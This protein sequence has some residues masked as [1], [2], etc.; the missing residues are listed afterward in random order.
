MAACRHNAAGGDRRCVAVRVPLQREAPSAT[1]D[2]RVDDCDVCSACFI[3]AVRSLCVCVPRRSW[4]VCARS[5]CAARSVARTRP[6]A[7]WRRNTRSSGCERTAL[8]TA[9]AAASVAAAA[10]PVHAARLS[11]AR[12][13]AACRRRRR[14][15]S[16]ALTAT[17]GRRFTH[18]W[19]CGAHCIATRL[20]TGPS[21]CAMLFYVWVFPVIP[22]FD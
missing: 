11:R 18:S 7:R 1:R 17:C 12:G 5:G 13:D 3:A 4:L 22:L 9:G 10:A 8:A 6:A 15:T 14:P 2:A 19:A 20:S 21:S 16:N